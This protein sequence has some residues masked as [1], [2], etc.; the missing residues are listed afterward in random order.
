LSDVGTDQLRR[1][2]GSVDNPRRQK[3]RLCGD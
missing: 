3:S 2:S 1:D